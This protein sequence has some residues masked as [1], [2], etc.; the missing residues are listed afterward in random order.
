MFD[1]R[2]VAKLHISDQDEFLGFELIEDPAEVVELNY[3]RDAAWHRA[4]PWSVPA[5]I[6]AHLYAESS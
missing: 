3:Q 2:T 5:L 4:I 6:E 1:S